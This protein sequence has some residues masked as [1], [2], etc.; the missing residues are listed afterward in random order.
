MIKIALYDKFT[1]RTFRTNFDNL[2]FNPPSMNCVK[3]YEI[4]VLDWFISKVVIV[5]SLENMSQKQEVSFAIPL[6]VR[7]VFLIAYRA[8]LGR[9][10]QFYLSLVYFRMPVFI[11]CQVYENLHNQSGLQ[12]LEWCLKLKNR[13]IWYVSKDIRILLI[14]FFK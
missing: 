11:Y 7:V 9:N 4:C 8:I 2:V 12:M 13:W 10:G 5:V 1:A 3:R 14:I 6:G